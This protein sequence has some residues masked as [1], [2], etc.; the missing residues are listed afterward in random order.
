M[1]NAPRIVVTVADPGTQA[2]PD[3]SRRKNAL[4]ADAIRRQGGEPI[5]LDASSSP[6]DRADAFESMDGLLL[7][8]GADMDPGRYGQSNQGSH[9]IEPERDAL[10]IEAWSAARERSAP[11]FGICRGFQVMNVLMGGTLL[12][13]VGGHAGPGWGDGPALRHPLRLASGSRL[14][15]ILHPSNAGGGVL[16][17]NSYHH[18][19][20]RRSDLADGLVAAAW[21][22]SPVG[23][24]VEAIESRDL[25]RLLIGV[26][27]HPERTESTPPA[28]ERLWRVFI[29][30]C[31]GP[32]SGRTDAREV[33]AR[34]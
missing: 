20:V 5:L 22:P 23:D 12:Q 9:E 34:R 1:S 25:G 28:F 3:V 29:D 24:I 33:P 13:D 27:C 30:A 6:A 8:G 32:A 11:V 31:R 2:R 14:A 18:Q 26:Q 15:R 16:S 7:A 19:A 17:V 10:E 21:S 4:Y